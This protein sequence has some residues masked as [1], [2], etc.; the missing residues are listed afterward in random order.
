MTPPERYSALDHVGFTVSDVGA[1][2]DFYSMML[3]YPPLL[4]KVWEVEYVAT[5]VGYPGLKMDVAMFN[6]PSGSLLEL[7]EYLE[8]DAGRVDMETY[9]V[10]NAHLCLT[11]ED[12][13][14]DF[15]RLRGHVEFRHPTPVEIPWGPYA[16]GWAAYIRDPDGITI[17]LLQAPPAGAQLEESPA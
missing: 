8:P 1:S 16:G 2:V 3:G 17:E 11:T 13:H 4:R 5:I 12:I 10:G 14:A 9:N 15:E 6:L 7:I